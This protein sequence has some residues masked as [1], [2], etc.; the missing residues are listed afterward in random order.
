MTSYSVPCGLYATDNDHFQLAELRVAEAHAPQFL[1]GL[2]ALVNQDIEALY[3]VDTRQN[4]VIRGNG[5]VTYTLKIENGSTAY[6]C[7]E[8]LYQLEQF[9]LDRLFGHKKPTQ[10]LSIQLT[11]EDDL[12]ISFGLWVGNK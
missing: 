3:L 1:T 10:C 2:R 9:T 5:T 11:G 7:E 8:N 12:Q 4:A 6:F